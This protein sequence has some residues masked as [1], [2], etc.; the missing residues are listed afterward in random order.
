MWASRFL[1]SVNILCSPP[2]WI[3]I[4]DFELKLRR[5]YLS[6]LLRFVPTTSTTPPEEV[7]PRI[8][9]PPYLI[10]EP[11]VRFID[12]QP[13]C[14]AQ[15]D[16]I[17]MLFSDG[18]DCLVDGCFNF[19]PDVHRKSNPCQ[20]V[21][22]LLQ[23]SVDPFEDP[24]KPPQMFESGGGRRRRDSVFT[25]GPVHAG[26]GLGPQSGGSF[27]AGTGERTSKNRKKFQKNRIK[28]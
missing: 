23:D 27:H 6:H 13:H 14:E 16:P 7:I 2:I 10:V 25:T 11:T 18:V 20:V 9:T 17:V 5:T 4:G 3:A 8:M 19:S 15:A 28:F 1:L 24:C 22:T 26:I 12:L 21:A